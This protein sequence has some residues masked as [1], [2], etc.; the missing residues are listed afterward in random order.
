MSDD[1]TILGKPVMEPIR[2]LETFP[3]PDDIRVVSLTSNELTSLCPITGQPDFSTVEIEYA[4]DGHCIESKSLKL[5]LWA[6]REE[7]HF[8]EAL[9]SRIANDVFDAAKPLWCQVTVRQNVRGGISIYATA[10]VRQDE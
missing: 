6:F 9:A 5:Y 1:L 10:K 3:A 7:G 8:C 4:P 2:K